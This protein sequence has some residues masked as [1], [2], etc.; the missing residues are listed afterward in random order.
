[1]SSSDVRIAAMTASEIVLNSPEL[2]GE[3]F[4]KCMPD[5]EDDNEPPTHSPLEAPVVLTHV[6]KAWRAVAL[7]YHR[8]WSRLRLCFKTSTFSLDAGLKLPCAILSEWLRRS[9]PLPFS[10]KVTFE[11]DATPQCCP[12]C[13]TR[14]TT[15]NDILVQHSHRW[16]ELDMNLN[17]SFCQLFHH[18]L[19]TLVFPELKRL[20]ASDNSHASNRPFRIKDAPKLETLY[21]IGEDAST[22]HFL[23]DNGLPPSLRSLTLEETTFVLNGLHSTNITRLEFHNTMISLH[24]FAKFPYFFPLLEE[25]TVS[26]E[27]AVIEPGEL[28]SAVVLGNLRFLETTTGY[29]FPIKYLTAPKLIHSQLKKAHPYP[30]GRMTFAIVLSFLKRSCPHLGRFY[31]DGLMMTNDEFV[32][33]LDMVPDLQM[34]EVTHTPISISMLHALAMPVELYGTV[35][36]LRCPKLVV[37]QCNRVMATDRTSDKLKT[38]R[39][40]MIGHLINN[41]CLANNGTFRRLGYPLKQSSLEMIMRHY[42]PLCPGLTVYSTLDTSIT[43]IT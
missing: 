22:N 43:R 28:P 35:R 3:I 10:L 14:D 2:L 29:E 6:N 37:F 34:L 13:M 32:A 26:Y 21:L 33:F 31:N 11:S 4:L 36:R 42:H 23:V 16:E 18:K 8:P 25:L 5:T 38:S 40:A 39:M 15:F 19:A 20:L 24:N 1:M 7:A 12:F 41:R 17:S 30:N 27:E 9:S